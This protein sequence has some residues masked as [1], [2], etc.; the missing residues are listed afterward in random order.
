MLHTYKAILDGDH[1]QWIDM[2]PER[3]RPVQVHITL[4][5][6]AEPKLPGEGAPVMAEVLAALA[7]EGTFSEIT[8]PVTWQ[9]EQRRDRGL[10]DREL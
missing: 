9:R 10:A 7:G 2:P 6:E 1:V 5:E 4:L 3:A 8:D